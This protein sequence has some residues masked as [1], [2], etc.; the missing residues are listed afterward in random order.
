MQPP[1]FVESY[2]DALYATVLACGGHKKVGVALR[3]DLAADAA[4]RWLADCCN[5]QIDRELHPLQLAQLRRLAR[6][7]EVHTLA[8]FEMQDAGYAEPQPIS[9]EDERAELER[10]VIS[11]L[12]E[13]KQLVARLENV[14]KRRR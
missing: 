7:M 4:G 1:L 9:P 13:F 14:T 6:D 3:P 8:A 5:P 10:R 11:S 2:Y 12:G